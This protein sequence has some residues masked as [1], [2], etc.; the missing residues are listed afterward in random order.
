[1]PDL[2]F[3]SPDPYYG[4]T[5]LQSGDT[6]LVSAGASISDS[7][8]M[9]A[10]LFSGVGTSNS[11]TIKGVV[12]SSQV[13]AIDLNEGCSIQIASTG[14]VR[15]LGSAIRLGGPDAGVSSVTNAGK[16]ENPFGDAW[17]TGIRIAGGNASIVNSGEITSYA[18]GI[19]AV[20]GGSLMVQNTGRIAAGNLGIAGSASNDVV[21]NSGTI[22]GD[23]YYDGIALYDGDDLYDGRS[24]NI[25]GAINLGKGND[26]AYGGSGNDY[27]LG[28]SGNDVFHRG[29][30][31]S[32][33]MDGGANTDTVAYGGG[34]G[35]TVD[36]SIVS[37]YQ[38]TGIG[39]DWLISIENIWS[40]SGNDLLKG[41]SDANAISGNG[42]DDTIM[43]GGGDDLLVGGEGNNLLE[44]GAG[45]DTLDGSN[46]AS[47]A[48][49]RNA[50]ADSAGHGLTIDFR[51]ADGSSNTGEA[52][53]DRYVNVSSVWGS[54]FADRLI[55]DDSVNWMLG[56]QGNDTISAGGGGDS[57]YGSDGDD[58]LSGDGGADLLVGGAGSNLLEGGAGADTLDGSGGASIAAYRGATALG[59]QGVHVDLNDTDGSHNTGDA[60]GDRHINIVGVWGSAFA[61]TLVGDG[62]ANWLL[63]DQGNDTL[64]G[65][66]GNDSLFGSDGDDSLAGGGG[67]DTLTGGAGND[68]YAVDDDDSIVEEIGGGSD[69]VEMSRNAALTEFDNVENLTLLGS[70][71]IRATGNEQANV[72][73]G[74]Q[75]RNTLDGASGADTLAG[76]SGDDTYIVDS[77][78]L[79]IE[80]TGEGNDAIVASVSYAL[81]AGSDV[82]ILQ[83]VAGAAVVHLTG[84]NS[85]NRL[86]GND[87][88]NDLKGNGGDDTLEGAVGND[89]LD[90]GQGADRMT[91]GSGD[92]T[93][94]ID[95]AAD[96]IV[97]GANG[98]LDTAI[99]SLNFRADA[100]TGVEI[101]K[102]ADN[103]AA[104]SLTGGA[105]SDHL[106][107]NAAFNILDGGSGADILEGGAGSDVFIVDN[108][109]DVVKEGAGG[110]ADAIQTTISYVLADSTAVEFLTALGSG[111]INLTGNGLANTISGN[112]S[113]NVLDGGAGA[114]RMEGAGGNDTYLVDDAGDLIL[115]SAGGGYDTVSA[116]ISYALAAGSEVETLAASGSASMHLTGNAFANT[117]LGNAAANF[118]RGGNGAD[119]LSG[120]LGGDR[121]FG[122][123]GRDYVTGGA[124]KDYFVLDTA[125]AKKKNANV[126]RFADF[127][128]RDDSIWLDNAV[129]KALGKKGSFAKPAKLKK[130]GFFF[131]NK[132]HDR[133]DHI[134]VKKTGKIYYDADGT[135]RQ[136]QIAIATVS[137]KVAKAMTEKDFFIV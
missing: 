27:F 132:A 102:L 63:G 87:A 17:S 84:S 114:D 107:G 18:Y 5:L 103:T 111:A 31:A 117:L 72:I 34:T 29:T 73:H 125:V 66:L 90:G 61:D 134:I 22:A 62:A 20:S 8:Q 110:G 35:L 115:E 104:V 76:G 69:T 96:L 11:I 33:V 3:N 89:T 82:E 28:F 9:S 122:G 116:R 126:D 64:D 36:L 118:L 136:A 51:H 74:N 95:S 121:L 6:V 98:G 12:R 85:A 137:K 83:A 127:S 32:N 25:I 79:V 109:G 53:G 130:D 105:G 23:Q 59:G 99:V 86:V 47:V 2:V 14:T 43:G 78:D 54:L 123:L 112:A 16:I 80:R 57:L 45:S 19:H 39:R 133:D 108:V 7:Y 15:G 26:T 21:I 93:Y 55:G 77:E 106:V 68:I 38:E 46:G 75:G 71:D 81:A 135:G 100:L 30:G 48:Y 119:V 88:D 41:N 97:E 49:Y 92:D 56:D 94:F 129:F 1:M 67:S 65:G 120:D 128:V 37:N 13:S 24:G 40:A 60:A 42:G 91:G 50:S 101:I 124:G 52:A 131:G 10:A 70:D 4:S 113:A 44:G 58:D